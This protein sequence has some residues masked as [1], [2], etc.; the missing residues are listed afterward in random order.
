MACGVRCGRML[1]LAL[2]PHGRH[3]AA[4]MLCLSAA[5]CR[6]HLQRPLVCTITRGR[7]VVDF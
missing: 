2:K 5:H 4:G 6:I 1:L 7:A 3:V